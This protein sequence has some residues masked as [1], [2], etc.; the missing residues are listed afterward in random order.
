MKTFVLLVLAA[1]LTFGEQRGTVEAKGSIGMTSFADEG[2]DNHLQTGGSV[3][4]YLNSRLSVEP[5][6][7]YLRGGRGHY[8]LVLMP[9][10]NWDFR[11]GQRV[12]PYVTAGIGL[13]HGAF[14]RF[15][16]N[17]WYGEFGAG[18]KLRFGPAWYI[19]PEFRVGTELD[20]RANVAIGYTFAGKR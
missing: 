14:G 11:P 20:A 17:Q 6:L 4:F 8:D 2:P 9:H 12:V 5:E 13:M 18:S 15:A 3:R 7:Q 19:A 1:A 16:T 10:V